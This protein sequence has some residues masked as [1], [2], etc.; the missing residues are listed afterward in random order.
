MIT[1]TDIG[2]NNYYTRTFILKQLVEDNELLTL[3]VRWVIDHEK[4]QPLQRTQHCR[5]EVGRRL[6][7]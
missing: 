4:V 1:L 7:C 2:Y 3:R 5:T 6:Q